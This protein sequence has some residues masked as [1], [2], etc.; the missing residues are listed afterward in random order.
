MGSV[1]LGGPGFSLT[2]HEGR[3][4]EPFDALNGPRL[5]G[6]GG[7]H[8]LHGIRPSDLLRSSSGKVEG[9]FVLAGPVRVGE[10]IEGTLRL[11]A[12]ET[13]SARKAALRLV[14][15]RLVEERK[16]VTHKTGEDTSYTE[17][18]V[19]ANGRL[20]VQDAYLAPV[21]PISL[22]PG[23][24]FETTFAVPAPRLGPPSAHLGEAVV[25]WAIEVRWDVPM[26]DDPFVAFPVPITQHPDLIRAGVGGQGGMA[27]LDTVNVE[28]ASISVTTPL[29]AA[30]G[31]NLGIRAS[32][33]G[34]PS[35][36]ARIELH[37]R[38]NAPNA[39]EGII[40]VAAT[41]SDRLRAG[42]A[43]AG[44]ALPSGSAPSFD[45]AD[46]EVTYVVRVLVDRRFMPDSAIERPVAVA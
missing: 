26:G 13:I 31:S 21:I 4:P 41:D 15:L 6:S 10:G 33:P 16:S 12:H 46:L 35:G 17:N 18:W 5:A 34:A 24:V 25:A 23:Q 43:E 27:L 30:P 45:G 40:A 22:A 19:E 3:C 9:E 2:G 1:S 7:S 42:T 14:G 28:G 11:T 44:L 38:T 37:R 8:P 36:P 32:W 39:E 29:P 20:F